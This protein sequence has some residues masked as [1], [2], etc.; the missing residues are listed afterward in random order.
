MQ[1]NGQ[2]LLLADL[3]YEA[4]VEVAPD[5]L[6]TQLARASPHSK[7]VSN[8]ERV[9]LIAHEQHVIEYEEGIR[10][11]A[12][13]ALV[14]RDL[15]DGDRLSKAISQ[16]WDWPPA[17]DSVARSQ[18]CITANELMVWGLEPRVRVALFHSALCQLIELTNPLAV[19]LSHAERIID[20]A[21]LVAASTSSEEADVL[22]SLINVRMFRIENGE[23]GD[24]V[25]DTRGLAELGLPDLQ[26]HFHSLDPARIA[27]HLYN[28]AFYIFSNGDCIR[29]GHTIDGLDA[30]EKWRCRLEN[31]LVPPER[32]VIDFDPGPRFA[33]GNRRI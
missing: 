13:T 14:P 33:A 29:D 16:T 8:R 12:Q 18:Y 19:H 3:L 6:S 17:S 4:R 11:P 7:L 10:V 9:L 31:A 27:G 1:N 22:R 5:R 24:L 32:V 23:N 2:G 20:P 25:M 30:I 21:V 15:P 28:S 26:I